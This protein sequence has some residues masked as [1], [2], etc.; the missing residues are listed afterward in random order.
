MKFRMKRHFTY[1]RG[2]TFLA[3]LAGAVDHGAAQLPDKDLRA[4]QVKTVHTQRTFP[5]I[6]SKREWEIRARDIRQQVLVSCGLWPL[7]EKTP[8]KANIF[9]RIERDDYTVE[10][11]YF[12]SYPGFYVAGNL[13]RPRGKGNGPF[14]GVLN[15]CGHWPNGR[16]ADTNH[17]SIPARCINFA[18]Q[19]MV[20]FSYDMVG[21]NDMTQLGAHRK[22]F[23]HP[24]L[25]LW[26]IS[27]MGLQ[28]WNS[29]RA[30]DFLESLPEV[31][32]T[33]LACTGESGGGTQTFML[34]GA[35]ARLAA[36]A[37]VCMVSHAFQG[38]CICENAPGLRVEYSNMEIAAVP[39][40]HP[41]ILVGCTGD[42]TTNTMTVE[43]PSIESVYRLFDQSDRLRY[44]C[45]DFEHNYNQTSR[46]AVYTWF[47]QWLLKSKNTNLVKE[48]S[49]KK[50]PDQDLRVWPDGK[51]PADALN[52]SELSKSLM[53]LNQ[54]RWEQLKPVD[55]KSLVKYKNTMMSLWRHTLQVEL[56]EPRNLLVETGKVTQAEAFNTTQFA[57]GRNGKADRIPLV[58]LTPTNSNSTVVILAHPSGKS[59]FLDASGAPTGLARELLGRGF[60]V[61]LPELFLTGELFDPALA[62]DRQYSEKFYLTY[63]N[64]TDAQERAQDL[65]TACV[66]ARTQAR[67]HHVVLC[68]VDRSGLLALLA[69]PAADAV[70]ADC[71]ALDVSEDDTLMAQDLFIPGIRNLGSFEGVAVLAL[72]RPILLHNTG[73]KFT[74]RSISEAYAV[75]G[76]MNVFKQESV[77]LSEPDLA[78]RISMIKFR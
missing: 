56:P 50:E 10:K 65:I 64:R 44:V 46:E 77:I 24:K 67:A 7:P 53:K 51:L 38:D 55:R 20:A 30:L 41:Q 8:L 23:R 45:F 78:A 42:W 52:E 26:N 59:K 28:T 34:G 69:A 57:L 25:Q 4:T 60:S 31:D 6:T 66:F 33:R 63:Y 37:P 5:Q 40:P 29:I 35:D 21:F 19:G 76:A 17:G 74:T 58:L 36:L 68:G 70:V 18:K 14:P 61:L 11:V 32:K 72:P 2:I 43:G 48:L 13:Y 15:T 75:A 71:A 49:Y 73:D 1:S 22:F 3:F 47:N 54:A 27:V 9:G 62:K 16:L 39:A 12:Q